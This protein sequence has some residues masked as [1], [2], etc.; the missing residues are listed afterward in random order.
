MIDELILYFGI[1]ACRFL[2]G[3]S[4]VDS[5]EYAYILF[6]LLFQE[7]LVTFVSALPASEAAIILGCFMHVFMTAHPST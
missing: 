3:V 4:S 7:F 1:L 5:D 6:L 2:Q